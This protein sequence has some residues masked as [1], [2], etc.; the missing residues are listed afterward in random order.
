M[1]TECIASL[2]DD[3]IG[4]R[5]DEGLVQGYLH[6]VH[7]SQI[8]F[9]G[10]QPVLLLGRSINTFLP[11]DEANRYLVRLPSLGLSSREVAAVVNSRP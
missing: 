3:C 6:E 7:T 5:R 11:R 1:T 4:V 8:L 2:H 10:D 9:S